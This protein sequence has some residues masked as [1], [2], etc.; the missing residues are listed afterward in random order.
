MLRDVTCKYYH[1][2]LCVPA[3]V[4]MHIIGA[5]GFQ[6]GIATSAVTTKTIM[7]T[8]IASKMLSQLLGVAVTQLE[9]SSQW[10]RVFIMP[11]CFEGG[12]RKA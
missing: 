11:C 5:T 6:I 4:T 12:T 8:I 10:K 7:L 1:H 2:H 9:L 3:T